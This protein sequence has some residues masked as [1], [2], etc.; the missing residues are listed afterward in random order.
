MA[1]AEAT[2]TRVPDIDASPKVVAQGVSK[3]FEKRGRTVEVLR[4]ISFSVAA[5]EFIAILGAS[6]CGKT[7]L[8]RIADGL[9]P[10]SGGELLINGKKRI[11]PGPD[12]GFVFQNDTLFPWRTVLKNVVLG[13]ELQGRSKKAAQQEAMKFIKLV[14][15]EGFEKHYPHE[16]SGGMRQ[17]ANLARAFTINPE[18][19]LMDEPFAALDAQ[20]REIMQT[21]LLR[22]W[23][24]T[25]GGTVLFITHQIDEAIFLADRVIV[26]TARPG[27]IKQIV[28][29]NFERPRDLSIKRTPEFVGLVDEVWRMIED[30]VKASMRM[31]A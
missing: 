2:V 24:E 11:A 5:G 19:L 8:L 28:D 7:T 12:R 16:L 14:G 10:V 30:E 25:E 15:L 22:I 27:R 3:S 1:R 18:V 20:T 31:N 4:D 29:V 9:E 6:G 23:G 26:L 13:L 21:E 17:R